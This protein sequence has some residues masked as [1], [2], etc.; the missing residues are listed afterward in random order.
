MD[1]VCINISLSLLLQ[2][3]YRRRLGG[4]GSGPAFPTVSAVI[5]E[6]SEKVDPEPDRR[7]LGKER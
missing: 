4:F 1:S 3:P 2:R 7:S 6:R 5:T